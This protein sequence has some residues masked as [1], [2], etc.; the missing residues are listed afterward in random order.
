MR[1]EFTSENRRDFAQKYAKTFGW[2]ATESGKRILV[3]I[4]DVGDYEVPFKDG[5]GNPYS[6][7]ANKG[8]M[9]EFLQLNRGLYN[10]RT[11]DVV[12]ASRSPQR[13]YQRGISTTNTKL[14]SMKSLAPLGI[15]FD[16]LE[17]VS[18]PMPVGGLVTQFLSGKRTCVA[19][20][21][22]LAFVGESVYLYDNCIG[23]V[24]NGKITLETDTFHQEVLDMVA[25]HALPL[26]IVVE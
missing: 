18:S 13:Q 24:K 9:F 25:R 15:T 3:Q 8:V 11:D 19:L 20:S 4:G 5:L 22:Q 23:S 21:E 12:Y 16:V 10:R 7:R 14:Y 6:A 26:E 17:E 2:Y 1:E